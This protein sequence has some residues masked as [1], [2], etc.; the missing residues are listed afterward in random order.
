MVVFQLKKNFLRNE[1]GR[2]HYL[3]RQIKPTDLKQGEK[4]IK[5]T[6]K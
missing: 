5:L 3:V 4:K 1:K 2:E 6:T